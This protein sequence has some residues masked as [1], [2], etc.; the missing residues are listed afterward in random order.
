MGGAGA[1]SFMEE[2]FTTLPP[3][4]SMSGSAARV[5]RTTLI[6]LM[7]T[8]ACQTA[9]GVSRKAGPPLRIRGADVVHQN[10]Q[11][12]EPRLR[13]P[14]ELP[15]AFLRSGID[16]HRI[17]AARLGQF[18]Q[19]GGRLAGGSE[20]RCARSGKRLRHGESDAAAGAGD[21]GRFSFQRYMHGNIPPVQS[22]QLMLSSIIAGLERHGK[23]ACFLVHRPA[24]MTLVSFFA[25]VRKTVVL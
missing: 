18:V 5:V 23:Y 17:D 16:G 8:I 6:R 20:H 3:C 19:R 1:R 15:R 21:D 22:L 10:V 24:R 13:F 4:F 9:S 12:A 11:S 2:M 7:S 25:L 14:G